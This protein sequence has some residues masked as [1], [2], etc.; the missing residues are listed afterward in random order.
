M[1]VCGNVGA[2]DEEDAEGHF[3]LEANATGGGGGAGASAAD[4]AEAVMLRSALQDLLDR[5]EA[6]QEMLVAQEVLAEQEEGRDEAKGTERAKVVR[7]HIENGP[8][9]R[10]VDKTGIADRPR[11]ANDATQAKQPIAPSFRHHSRMSKSQSP[12]RSW[13]SGLRGGALPVI[14]VR[15]AMR[16]SSPSPK[17]QKGEK[18]ISSTP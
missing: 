9:V 17:G 11:S 5:Y 18:T 13:R 6:L 12:K 14:T 16:F 8:R 1:A 7:V 15:A 3:R 2:V 4:Q 10:S